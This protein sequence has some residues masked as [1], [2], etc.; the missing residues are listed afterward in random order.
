MFLRIFFAVHSGISHQPPQQ[1]CNLTSIFHRFRAT[2][3]HSKEETGTAAEERATMKRSFDTMQANSKES[4]MDRSVRFSQWTMVFLIDCAD[5]TTD[6]FYGK[7]DFSQFQSEYL[8]EEKEAGK[9]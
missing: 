7:R 3:K 2:N 5:T 4:S 6:L 8:E 1:P 9:K